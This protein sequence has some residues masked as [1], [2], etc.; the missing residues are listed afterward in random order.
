M[1]VTDVD[2]V[3]FAISTD[4]AALDPLT[5]TCLGINI[6]VVVEGTWTIAGIW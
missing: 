2:P 4:V 5:Y 3:K 1:L 6:T